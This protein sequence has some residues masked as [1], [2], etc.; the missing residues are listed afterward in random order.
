MPDDGKAPSSA[1]VFA[2]HRAHNSPIEGVAA[3]GVEP[4]PG[5]NGVVPDSP[6][7]LSQQ[8]Q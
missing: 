4:D 7:E 5:Q 6:Q 3:P 2:H 8:P 1:G